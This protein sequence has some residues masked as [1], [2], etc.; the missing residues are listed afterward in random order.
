M[1]F[2]MDVVRA[3]LLKEY[4]LLQIDFALLTTGIF[5]GDISG[6][7]VLRIYGRPLPRLSAV[8]APWILNDCDLQCLDAWKGFVAVRCRSK[9]RFIGRHGV[10]P[11]YC[12]MGYDSGAAAGCFEPSDRH[13]PTRRPEASE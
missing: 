5:A 1:A 7:G 12:N 2:A 9:K 13:F 8:V 10:I 3:R 6:N 11:I 4:E